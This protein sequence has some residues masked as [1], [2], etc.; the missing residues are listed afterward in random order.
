MKKTVLISF[1]IMALIIAACNNTPKTNAAAD[2]KNPPA[3]KTELKADCLIGTW[4]LIENDAEKTF[5]FNADSTGNE[6][7]SAEEIRPFKWSY[8]EG[9]PVIVYDNETNEW[10]FELDCENAE[11]KIMGVIYKKK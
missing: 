7:Y 3:E 4:S 1:A 6:V 5:T 11:L 2:E 8:Q 10:K 9:N